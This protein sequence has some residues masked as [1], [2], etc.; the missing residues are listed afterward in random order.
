MP[1][2]ASLAILVGGAYFVTQRETPQRA[3]ASAQYAESERAAQQVVLALAIASE[4]LSEAQTKVQ[5]ISNH[6]PQI[7]H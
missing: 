5:E 2:A 3:P 7:A 4:K 1:I 6:E